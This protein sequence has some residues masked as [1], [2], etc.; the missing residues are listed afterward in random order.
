MF[1]PRAMER[2]LGADDQ[3]LPPLSVG[4]AAGIFL[5]LMVVCIGSGFLL[6]AYT[7]RHLPLTQVDGMDVITITA[8]DLTTAKD[9]LPSVLA[10]PTV[11]SK[12]QAARQQPGHRQLVYFIP[13]DYVMQGMI[14]DTGPEWKL[15][16]HYK[17]FLMIAEYILHPFAHLTG[18]HHHSM[19]M[20]HHDPSLHNNPMMKRRVIFIDLSH[21]AEPLRSAVDQFSINVQRTPLF[22]VDVHLHTGEVLDVQ[23]LAGGS[24]WG[25]VPTPMF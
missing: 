21:G 10:D 20:A 13:I 16:E 19:T 25:R 8:E 24:G 15:F 2:A 11:A 12:L 6:R 7:V 3:P 18:G 23:T 9:L 22:F 1:L 14:A 4:K 5:G 17:T